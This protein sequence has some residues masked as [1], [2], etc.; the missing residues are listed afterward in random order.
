MVL[1]AGR[2][3]DVPNI[4]D[5]YAWIGNASGVATPTLLADVATSGDYDDLTNKPTITPPSRG[6]T[7]SYSGYSANRTLATEY[8]QWPSSLSTSSTTTMVSSAVGQGVSDG[9]YGANGSIRLTGVD[10]TDTVSYSI[11][12]KITTNNTC[13]I[14]VGSPVSGQF[15]PA[16]AVAFAS[17]SE[18]TFVLQGA[19]SPVAQAQGTELWKMYLQVTPFGT[20][21]YRVSD[22]SITLS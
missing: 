12:L 21:T 7:Y 4:A 6:G 1:G 9:T 15:A 11:T 13:L 18:Q 8:Y 17:G 19:Y 2:S 5:G 20:G 16:T 14:S 10:S 3:N 22:F